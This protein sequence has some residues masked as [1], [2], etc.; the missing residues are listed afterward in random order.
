MRRRLAFTVPELLAVIAIVMIII[1]MLLPAMSKAKRHA[2]GV[3][4]MSNLHQLA[5]AHKG[6]ANDNRQT[7][8]HRE[9][10]LKDPPGW[11]GGPGYPYINGIPQDSILVKFRYLDGL[12][13]F[14]CPGDDFKRQDRTDLEPYWYRYIRPATFSYTRNAEA[15][16]RSLY[17]STYKIRKPSQTCLTAEESETAPMNGSEFYANNYDM[18]TARHDGNCGMNFFDMHAEYISTKEFNTS[19]ASVRIDRWLNP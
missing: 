16:N 3:V 13:A 15:A 7:H 17:P 9:S 1:A 8:C 14:T 5:M 6:Y 11:V 10:F 12:D 2:Q 19:S 4:C 18:M